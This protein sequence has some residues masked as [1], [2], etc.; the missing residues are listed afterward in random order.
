M[1]TKRNT[2]LYLGGVQVTEKESRDYI[3]FAEQ[4]LLGVQRKVIKQ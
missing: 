1:R 2:D 3:Q 4:V